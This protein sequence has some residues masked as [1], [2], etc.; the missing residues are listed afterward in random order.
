VAIVQD[1]D[2]HNQ[3]SRPYLVWPKTW[4]SCVSRSIRLTLSATAESL[5]YWTYKTVD[6]T[7]PGSTVS[8]FAEHLFSSEMDC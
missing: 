3:T 6:F 7:L 2:L 1:W 8:A 4:P 5:Y